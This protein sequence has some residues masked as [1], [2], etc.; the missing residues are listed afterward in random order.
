[1]KG[2]GMKTPVASPPI[3]EAVKNFILDWAERTKEPYE[4]LLAGKKIPESTIMRMLDPNDIPTE[5][6]L[7]G[8]NALNFE[9]ATGQSIYGLVI[10]QAKTGLWT[11][12]DHLPEIR[13]HEHLIEAISAVYKVAPEERYKMFGTRANF[14]SRRDLEEVLNGR[15]L[16]WRK[17]PGILEVIAYYKKKVEPRGAPKGESAF[18][19][20]QYVESIMRMD[21]V[22]LGCVVTSVI[23]LADLINTLTIDSTAVTQVQRMSV[24]R[25]LVRIAQKFGITPATLE[26]AQP[27]HSGSAA[28]EVLTNALGAQR[29]RR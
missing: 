21:Q 25:G 26:R 3:L 5:K 9:E 17:I 4:V 13:T 12:V 19:T 7:L 27:G 20:A 22:G 18:E 1:M 16:Y 8:F 14:D 11:Q 24:V 29:P 6:I 10:A 15:P 2:S 28:L 23:S